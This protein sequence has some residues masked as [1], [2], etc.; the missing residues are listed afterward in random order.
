MNMQMGHFLNAIASGVGNQPVSRP[1][2]AGGDAQL[3]T[4]LANGAGEIRDLCVRGVQREMVMADIWPF[5]DDQHMMG[6]FGGDICEGQRVVGFQHLGAG[7]LAAQD[8]RKDVLVVISVRHRVLL[9][10]LGL[11]R[12]V[13]PTVQG[14]T[15][16][17]RTGGQK[18]EYPS[19]MDLAQDQFEG[20]WLGCGGALVYREVPKAACSTLAQL[21]YHADHGA[22][23]DGDIHDAREGVVKWPFAPEAMGPAR[24]GAA[25]VFSAVRNP[26]A[27]IVST[28]HEK[29]CTLQ[30]DGKPYRGTMRQMLAE[31]YGADLRAGADPVRAFRR[32]LLFVR[33]VHVSGQRFWF[34]RHWTPQAQHLR[35]VTLNDVAFSHLFR[36]EDWDS[37]IVPVLA[38]I[39]RARRPEIAV[40]FNSGPKPVAPLAEYFDE[41][42]V[43]FMQELYRWDFELFGYDRF[44]PGA[45]PVAALDL[46]AINMRLADP[47]A[48]HWAGLGG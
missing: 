4:D 42:S 29:V 44:D 30:R 41:L 33:D 23:F 20:C 28:F 31:R 48:P 16:E 3:R 10:W 32:F 36:I 21:V 45:R 5:G 13:G 17:K 26:F 7:N 19:G 34:D 46:A 12:K 35:A 47:H 43:H 38:Q 22:F 6:R 14:V 1:I 27:R 2:R 18:M 24:E 25:F 39:P 9:Q 15:P 8:F 11:A 37:G 40:R